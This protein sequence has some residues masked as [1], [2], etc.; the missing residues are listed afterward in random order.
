VQANKPPIPPTTTIEVGTPSMEKTSLGAPSE[1]ETKDEEGSGEIL[2]KID[3]NAPGVYSAVAPLPVYSPDP[4]IPHPHV[5]PRGDPPA[6]NPNAHP[7]PLLSPLWRGFVPSA[8]A[9][10]FAQN[11]S[12]YRAR[13]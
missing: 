2:P 4:P 11:C 10:R 8:A 13:D 9:S 12:Y 7:V 1:A 6:L 3:P 5:T